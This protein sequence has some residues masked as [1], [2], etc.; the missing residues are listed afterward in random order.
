MH[1]FEDIFILK[2]GPNGIQISQTQGV[3]QVMRFAGTN[4]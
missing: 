2:K 3:N 1:H 4:L